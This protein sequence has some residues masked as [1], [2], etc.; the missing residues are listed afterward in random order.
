MGVYVGLVT[1]GVVRLDYGARDWDFPPENFPM[2]LRMAAAGHPFM[3]SSIIWSKT[4]FGVTLLRITTD[5]MKRA[6]LVLII[7][8]NVFLGFSILIFYIQCRPIQA[9]WDITVTG[10]CWSRDAVIGYHIFSGSEFPE[11]PLVGTPNSMIVWSAA[12]DLTLVFFP[13]KLLWGAQV[14]R[15]EKLGIAA[16]M[17]M[18]IL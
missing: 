9:A 1:Y 12:V 15:T 4:S 7:S 14:L 10:K 18:G 6:V 17:S 3:L 16:A 13:W 8:T 11:S 5:W 2:I